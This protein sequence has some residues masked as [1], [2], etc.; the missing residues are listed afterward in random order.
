MNREVFKPNPEFSKNARIKNMCEY[1]ELQD[2]A[3]RDYEGF[4]GNYAK[5]K[6]EWMVPFTNVLDESN[7]P[8]VKVV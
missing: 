4:W 1:N 3:M 8:F 5:E 7:Y 6:L 2:F